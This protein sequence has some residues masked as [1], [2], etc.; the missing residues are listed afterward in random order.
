M[1]TESKTV[2]TAPADDSPAVT[3]EK[4]LE[5]MTR[6]FATQ[7]MQPGDILQKD[8]EHRLGISRDAIRRY[9]ER[10]Y[11]DYESVEIIHNRVRCKAYRKKKGV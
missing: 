11:P 10:N 5:E 4:L 1:A 3:Y 2:Q 9:M 7:R 8:L 6:G